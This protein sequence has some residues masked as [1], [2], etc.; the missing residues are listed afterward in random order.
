MRPGTKK[1]WS[2]LGIFAVVWLSARFLI[3]LFSPFL[4]GT[5][6]AL[7]AEPMVRFL[8]KKVRVPRP[9]SAGIGVSMTFFFGAMLLLCL[10]AFLLRELQIL[11]GI[12]PDLE[13]TARSGFSLIRSWLLDLSMHAPQSIQPLLMDNMDE[14]FSDGTALL[15]KGS[16]WLLNL[17]GNLLSHIPDSALGLGTSVISAFLISS[18]LPRIKK[19]L[20]KR[21]SREKLRSFLD[22]G[23]RLKK[24]LCSFLLAQVKLMG[25]TFLILFLGLVI[26]R[27]PYAF[28]WALGI[29]LVDAFP[30]L[31]TGTILLPWSFLCLL[32]NDSPRAIGIASLYVVITLTRSAL[33]PRLLGLHLGLDP[34]VTLM[35][36][37][38]GY[39]I[40]GI[41]GMIFGPVLAVTAL[42]LLPD[43]TRRGEA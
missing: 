17:A 19:W 21:I 28:V 39:K 3:P 16:T 5:A 18:K 26:L 32:Q 25:V 30:I 36:M 2:L 24:V 23:R 35:V 8:S 41:G 10:C 15:S 34:L 33:E 13:Q 38:A 9:I 42:Q 14:F 31:G 20:L 29:C 4:L 22:T 1:T 6:L 27:V 40:F 7:A 43:T 12:L 11:S 37:Y